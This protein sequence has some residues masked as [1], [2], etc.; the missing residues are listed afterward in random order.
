M[1]RVDGG[2]HVVA[3]DPGALAAGRHRT[4]IGIGQRDL[5]VGR[6][7]HARFHLLELLHLLLQRGDL[8]LQP[9]AILA[10]ATV[11]LLPIGRVQLPIG[12]VRCW[13]RSAP[14]AAGS[15]RRA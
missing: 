13:L 2:L 14:S 6:R 3:D 5:L 12:S 1:L 4:R 9:D 11:A 7:Q 15:W 10:S 8:V